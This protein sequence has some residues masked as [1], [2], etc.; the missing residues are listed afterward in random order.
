MTF[1]IF[2]SL[3][4]TETSTI[5]KKNPHICFAQGVERLQDLVMEKIL[6]TGSR[7]SWLSLPLLLGQNIQHLLQV[8]GNVGVCHWGF[9]IYKNMN[10]WWWHMVLW[11]KK[12]TISK[13]DYH[14]ISYLRFLCNNVWW[15]SNDRQ[16]PLAMA[17]TAQAE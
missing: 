17:V 5:S 13:T 2:T 10:R 4:L 15:P 1:L 16:N 8:G 11:L 3:Q 6:H 14:C 7:L 9:V 12:S